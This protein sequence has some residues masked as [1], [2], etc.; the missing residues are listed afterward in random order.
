MLYEVIT[1]CGQHEHQECTALSLVL[2]LCRIDF[3]VIRHI[4]HSPYALAGT[5]L[6]LRAELAVRTGITML[7]RP[8]QVHNVV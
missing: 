1:D 7:Y 8:I 6:A 4:I 3:V 2:K 5:A